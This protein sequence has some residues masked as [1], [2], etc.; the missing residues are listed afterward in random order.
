L[1]P[2]PPLVSRIVESLEEKKGV[3]IVVL[4]IRDLVAYTDYLVICSGTSTTHVSALVDAVEEKTKGEKPVYVNP[5]PDDS[6]WVVDLI[7]VVVH[8]FKEDVRR[9]YDLESLWCD[10]KITGIE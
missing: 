7:N 2:F 4:D 8:V 1:E 3:D 6:W 9:F 10:A 5:S